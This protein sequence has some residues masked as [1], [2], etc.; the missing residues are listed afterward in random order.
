MDE[1][2]TE[3][4]LPLGVAV[5]IYSNDSGGTN[6]SFALGVD[7]EPDNKVETCIDGF[8][9]NKRLGSDTRYLLS[10]S[11]DAVYESVDCY[12]ICCSSVSLENQGV[13]KD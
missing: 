10:G 3:S 1:K 11:S 12:N 6:A 9:P 5:A 4:V 8:A 7:N 13:T 2:V